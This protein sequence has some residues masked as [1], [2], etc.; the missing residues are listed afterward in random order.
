M[1][2]MKMRTRQAPIPAKVLQYLH[3]SLLHIVF[4]THL[5]CGLASV[6]YVDWDMM[7]IYLF[8]RCLL[9]SAQPI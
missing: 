1:K 5:F 7:L 9:A 2:M 6:V 8:G 3:D 4:A